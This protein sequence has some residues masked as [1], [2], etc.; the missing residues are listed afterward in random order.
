MAREK[1]T[2]I[3][4]RQGHIRERCGID[5][6]LPGEV[7]GLTAEEKEKLFLDMMIEVLKRLYTTEQAGRLA[8]IHLSFHAA[9]MKFMT[10]KT[11][12]ASVSRRWHP[13]LVHQL[14]PATVADEAYVPPPL[15]VPPDVCVGEV[16]GRLDSLPT[17]YESLESLRQACLTLGLRWQHVQKAIVVLLDEKK[18][19]CAQ[20]R[21]VRG[22][23]IFGTLG[24]IPAELREVTDKQELVRAMA[25]Y[26]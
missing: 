21:D 20:T 8:R 24:E 12:H 3:A 1:K 11:G 14:I 4:I 26:P 22:T 23:Y 2:V 16:V 9:L 6:N 7:S 19:W 15:L 25:C 13:R 18:V 17:Q 5:E 10:L